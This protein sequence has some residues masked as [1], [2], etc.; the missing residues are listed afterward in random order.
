MSAPEVAGADAS[1]ASARRAFDPR[2]IERPTE[3]YVAGMGPSSRLNTF[4]VGGLFLMAAT[5]G[6]HIAK[7]IL[8]PIVLALLFSFLFAPIVSRLESW[9]FPRWAAAGLVLGVAVT[10]IAWGTARLFEPAVDW[11]AEAPDRIERI[12][13][14]LRV[15][16]APVEQVRDAA[17]EA[18][19]RVESA[20]GDDEEQPTVN[21]ESTSLSRDMLAQARGLVA[22]LVV[23]VAL[24]F[25]FLSS[26]DLFLRK[27]VRVLPRYSA[28]K[29]AVRVSRRIRRDV[30]TQLLAV[31]VINAG[32][33][34]AI[35]LT[36]AALDVP[37]PILWGAMA[38][39][40]N[41]IPYLGAIA[42]VAV[43]AVVALTTFDEVG[44]ALMVP[45]AY[46]LLTAL[47]G[48]F[49][50][51]SVLGHTMRLN[52]AAIFIGVLVFAGLWG[53][54]GALLA[55]PLLASV[56]AIADAYPGLLV[57]SEFLGR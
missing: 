36:M 56:K 52:P 17:D 46:L 12:E 41:F 50:T 6:L 35:G 21:V 11:I 43:V 28:R 27:L 44:R 34:V 54:A 19:E 22:G 42:G 16:S 48:T 23:T 2:F 30:S 14:K 7:P 24:T 38:A 55:V 25:F 5:Y 20:L 37:N 10:G 29:R 13:E 49:V 40:L 26:G 31:S 8:L 47:E 33:G 4:F 45:G 9:R 1:P 15:I 51:P 39:L 18:A 53:I 32:L 57:V 3:S